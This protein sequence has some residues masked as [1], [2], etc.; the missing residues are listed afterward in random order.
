MRT[1]LHPKVL[2]QIIN[3]RTTPRKTKRAD[4]CSPLL[5]VDELSVLQLTPPHSI[6]VS[7]VVD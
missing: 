7:H 5:A 2:L 3:N 6:L 4:F 1:L